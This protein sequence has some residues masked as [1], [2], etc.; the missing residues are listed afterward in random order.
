[1]TFLCLFDIVCMASI[2]FRNKKKCPKNFYHAT[3]QIVTHLT[4]YQI[5][6][7]TRDL[8]KCV[9]R[10]KKLGNIQVNHYS[11]FKTAH[12]LQ[13]KLKMAS[14]WHK[15]V[16]YLSLDIVCSAKLPVFL[17]LHSWETV[18]FL[19]QIM[20]EDEYLSMFS[21]QTE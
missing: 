5:F 21:H 13:K 2:P 19:E 12:M 10:L 18:C 3:S 14:I 16:K 20:F 17:K 4:I 7:L 11:I 1:M 8:S 15:N 6:L 9:T